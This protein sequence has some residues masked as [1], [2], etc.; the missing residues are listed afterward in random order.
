MGKSIDDGGTAFPVENS[1]R[2]NGDF[3]MSLRDYFAGQAMAPMITLMQK[4][5]LKDESMPDATMGQ[6]V[7]SQAYG[8]AFDMLKERER[9]NDQR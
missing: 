9:S 7:A 5:L 3:G 2:V 1:A 6:I 8:V 4:G